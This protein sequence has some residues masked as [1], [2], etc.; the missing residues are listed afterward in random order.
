M[1]DPRTAATDPI[2]AKQ[3][4]GAGFSLTLDE[5]ER[6]LDDF[7]RTEGDPEVVQFSGGEPSIHPQIVPMLRAA[8]ARAIRYVMLNTNGKRIA[9][10]DAFVAELA[11][12]RP[13]V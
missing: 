7:I 2:R 4:A 1:T 10:D 3:D 13:W 11:D 8:K 6:I 9:S 12:I 5:V